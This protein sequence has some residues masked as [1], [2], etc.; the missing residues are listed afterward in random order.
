MVK[1]FG[2]HS[3][4][5]DNSKWVEFTKFSSFQDDLL[6]VNIEIDL[7]I[8]R[9]KDKINLQQLIINLDSKQFKNSSDICEYLI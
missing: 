5:V 7:I 1:L 9:I 6:L 2:E 4:L 8:N 3:I